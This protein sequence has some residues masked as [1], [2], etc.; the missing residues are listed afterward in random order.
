MKH[1][2]QINVGSK[3]Y[4]FNIDV[5]KE[6]DLT[7]SF[8]DI[9]S[10]Y[11]LKDKNNIEVLEEI[12]N[13]L[14]GEHNS[15]SELKNILNK[16]VLSDSEISKLL[17]SYAG[18]TSIYNISAYFNASRRSDKVMLL[19]NVLNSRRLINISSYDVILMNGAKNRVLTKNNR[20]MLVI[21]PESQPEEVISLLS[22]VYTL[23]QLREPNSWLFKQFTKVIDEYSGELH[24]D[25]KDLS[26]MDKAIYLFANPN[27][28]QSVRDSLNGLINQDINTKIKLTDKAKLSGSH[29]ENALF[30]IM[31]D[32]RDAIITNSDGTIGVTIKDI[33]NFKNGLWNSYTIKATEEEFKEAFGLEEVDTTIYKKDLWGYLIKNKDVAEVVYDKLNSSTI[34]KDNIKDRLMEA[35]KLLLIDN[36]SLPE[37]ESDLSFTPDP[38]KIDIESGTKFGQSRMIKI[39]YATSKADSKSLI[40][41]NSANTVTYNGGQESVTIPLEMALN[42]Y[43]EVK[44][45]INKYKLYNLRFEGNISL[46]RTE[47]IFKLYRDNLSYLTIKDGSANDIEYVKQANIFG[48]QVSLYAGSNGNMSDIL[49]KY[50]SVMPVF[51]KPLAA[52]YKPLSY[53]SNVF[54]SIATKPTLV[55]VTSSNTS[56]NQYSVGESFKLYNEKNPDI[57]VGVTLT[58]KIPLYHQYYLSENNASIEQGDLI[59]K[60]G[61]HYIFVERIDENSIKCIDLD[62]IE[63]TISIVN[64]EYVEQGVQSGMKVSTPI[65]EDGI[66]WYKDMNGREHFYSI[67]EDTFS[68]LNKE[69]FFKPRIEEFS[70]DS[71]IPVESLNKLLRDNKKRLLFRLSPSDYSERSVIHPATGNFKYYTTQ[72]LIER[73]NARLTKGIIPVVWFN[74]KSTKADL[75]FS[76]KNLKDFKAFTHDGIIYMN[77]DLSTIDSYVHELSHI[78]LAALR[79]QDP[80]AY[81]TLLSKIDEIPE[82]FASIYQGLTR[83][84]LKEEYLVHLFSSY[85][86]DVDSSVVTDTMDS[87]DWETVVKKIFKLPEN[88]NNFEVVQLMNDT[89]G[90]M[91][92]STEDFSTYSEIF[93]ENKFQQLTKLAALKKELMENNTL[94]EEC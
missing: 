83:N 44:V 92:S 34:E 79:T 78:I 29:Q 68:N 47:N 9:I 11:I 18:N 27:L 67:E 5:S 61:R 43:A 59:L 3:K 16:E 51:V 76:I 90:N 20:T 38:S 7:A 31:I 15:S 41:S 37:S 1:C 14:K 12:S 21:N 49:P 74:R 66:I 85:F 73:I 42:N 33:I 70:R 82:N 84:D 8:P 94:K 4:T 13:S 10:K 64:L 93:K 23:D 22:T 89:I 77:E 54:S 19:S 58:E 45:L 48:Y 28:E 30:D 25:I 88:L 24:K 75:G 40:I 56:M 36:I 46:S 87:I 81:N 6:A 53:Q 72:D 2:I 69:D 80:N 55:P 91:L 65:S 17:D 32:N 57:K 26:M 39:R 35:S 60:T 86:T 52:K 71:G 63:P 50:T 62:S